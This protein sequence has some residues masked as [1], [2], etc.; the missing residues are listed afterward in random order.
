MFCDAHNHFQDPLFDDLQRGALLSELVKMGLQYMVVN[1]T[2]PDDWRD[3]ELLAVAF[4]E[5][6]VPSFGL[7]PWKVQAVE[8]GWFE[9]LEVFVES[10]KGP[11]GMGEIGLDR[12]IE[13]PDIEK[14]EDA[15]RRQLALATERDLPVMIHCLRAWGPLMEILREVE[16]PR[17]G[18]LIHSVGASPELV[19]ELAE[20]G[21]YFSAS[22]PFANPRKTKYQEALKAVPIDRLLIETDAPGMLPPPS[23]KVAFLEDPK[24][25]KEL[26]HPAN[27]LATYIYVREFFGLSEEEVLTQVFDNFE[28]FFLRDSV[29]A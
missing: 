2:A 14:Q 18:F 6:I 5:V 9:K 16:L 8:D 13:N 1:G 26:C 22:G 11:V 24:T 19:V 29:G 7:H 15:F 23:H 10:A 28:R 25:G 3:V 12:W 27:L 20:M 4:P 21:G 17:R